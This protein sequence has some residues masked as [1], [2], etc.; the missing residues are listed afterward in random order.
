MPE[1]VKTFWCEPSG[2]SRIEFIRFQTENQC[3]NRSIG[4]G[5]RA[6]RYVVDRVETEDVKDYAPELSRTNQYCPKTCDY[7]NKPFGPYDRISL[8]YP[9][10]YI[11]A[12]HLL[13]RHD[14]PAGAMWDAGEYYKDWDRYKSPDGII[15]VVKLPNGLEFM[16]D[17]PATNRKE[18]PAWTRTGDPKLA[19]LTVQGSIASGKKGTSKY[20][21]GF[22]RNGILEPCGDSE[23]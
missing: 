22:L 18:V 9:E 7:C 3:P 8:G 20:Y 11:G 15:V 5:C 13:T 4:Q 17:G 14:L 23:C 2:V 12:T 16:P 21:H 19:N 6:V 1:K 10:Y